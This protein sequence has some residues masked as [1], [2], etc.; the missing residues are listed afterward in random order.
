MQK[1]ITYPPVTLITPEVPMSPSVHGGRAKCLQRLIRLEMPVPITVALSFAAVRAVAA[2]AGAV[3][4]NG[5]QD[6]RDSRHVI[7]ET[8]VVV[9]FIIDLERFDAVADGMV[10]K[11]LEVGSPVRID[12][13]IE[14]AKTSHLF[15]KLL[16]RFAFFRFGRPVNH[17][18]SG[19][20]FH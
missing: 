3:G 13:P 20:F 19:P 12:G 8:H 10:R 18:H 11:G 4:R 2:L 16:S 7:D 1:E 15:Q 6:R 14:I 17:D 9:P 5:R